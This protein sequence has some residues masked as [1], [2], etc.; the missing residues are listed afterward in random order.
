MHAN[1]FKELSTF[2]KVFI[3]RRY[4]GKRNNTHHQDFCPWSFFPFSWVLH[5]T[6]IANNSACTP[7]Q[8]EK[9]I[10]N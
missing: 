3:I 10:T 4:V 5:P 6:T 7:F 2:E 8:Y 1:K 9:L